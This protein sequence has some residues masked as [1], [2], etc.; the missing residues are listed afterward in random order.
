MKK[1]ISILVA[2]AVAALLLMVK[3][4]CK[5]GESAPVNPDRIGG[6]WSINALR[7][8]VTYPGGTIKDTILPWV[9]VPE[10]FVAFLGADRLEYQFNQSSPIVG[11]YVYDGAETIRLT[12]NGRTDTYN[13]SLLTRTNFN[14][15]RQIPSHP[16]FPGATRIMFYQ[17]FVR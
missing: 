7:Y 14:I 16:S 8:A 13:V 3:T 17:N 2:L 5:K 12:M 9:P 11:T 15:E 6:K 4:G 1:P 10:N